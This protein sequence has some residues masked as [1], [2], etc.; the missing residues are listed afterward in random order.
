[1]AIALPTHARRGRRALLW[2]VAVFALAQFGG[3]LLLDYVWPELRFPT[4]H[5]TFKA[6]QQQPRSPDVMCLG[7]SRFGAGFQQG[8][9]QE[10][11]RDDT[12]DAQVTVFNAAIEAGDL[13]TADYIMEHALNQGVRPRVVVIEVSPETLARRC[14][15]MGQHV[16]RQL[17]WADVPDHLG[18]VWRSEN[19]VRLLSARLLPLYMHRQQIC[20]RTCEGVEKSV[21]TFLAQA[22]QKKRKKKT[23]ETVNQG[24]PWEVFMEL[25]QQ[26]ANPAKTSAGLP[27]VR[28]AL[29]DY[30]V[31]GG[32]ARALERLVKRCRER[33][34]QVVL[35]G[36]PVTE[37]H[38]ACTHPKSTMPSCAASWT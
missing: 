26:V 4:A 18:D 23:P 8:N 10:V 6:L 28:R 7:S 21:Q 5:L 20:R 9:I 27:A 29:K 16:L 37:A 31:G 1:M 11:L 38:R 24:V 13:V 36:V 3:G 33:D 2:A 32:S 34:I 17:T 14:E 15:W 12:G 30:G 22:K 19:L 35:V 25:D